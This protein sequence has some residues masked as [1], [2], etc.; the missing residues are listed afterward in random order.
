[1][2]TNIDSEKDE[3]NTIGEKFVDAMTPGFEAEFDPEEAEK[4]GAFNEDAISE[5]DALN[6]TA[7]A[8]INRG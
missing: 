4:V 1:M 5:I 7:D 3:Q 2:K 8:L 6:S